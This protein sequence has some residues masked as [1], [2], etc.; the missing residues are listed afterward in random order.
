[1][2]R[3][4]TALTFASDQGY[5]EMVKAL[6]TAGA[7]VNARTWNG[8]TALMFACQQYGHLEVVQALVAAHAD[9]N[10]KDAVSVHPVIMH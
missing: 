10:V 1:M 3:N 9:P 8:V 6:V 4:E 5:L 2:K 7:D